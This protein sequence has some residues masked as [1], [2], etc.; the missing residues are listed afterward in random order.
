MH[1]RLLAEAIGIRLEPG[2]RE[3]GQDRD[4]WNRD[5]HP[6][7]VATAPAGQSAGHRLAGETERSGIRHGL[8]VDRQLGRRVVS[9]GRVGGQATSQDGLEG[10]GNRSAP[11]AGFGRTGSP[12]LQVSERGFGPG[13]RNDRPAADRLQEDQTQRVQ[14]RSVVDPAGLVLDQGL[15]VL[16]SHVSERAPDSIGSRG[17]VRGGVGQVEVQEHGQ[18]VLGDE[19]V[20][21]LD[22]AVQHAALVRVLQGLGQPRPPPGDR[23][24][25]GPPGQGVPTGRSWPV[26][27]GLEPVERVDERGPG[28]RGRRGRLGQDPSQGQPAEVRHAEEMEPSRRVGT[29]GV[30]G[31]NVGM[32]QPCQGLRLARAEPGD[33]EHD[34]P[35]GQPEL[36]GAEHPAKD[37]RPSSSTNRKPAIVCPDSGKLEP[38]SGSGG[39][40]AV[41][42]HSATKP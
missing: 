34:R 27:P 18:A 10:R 31:D 8:K 24:R 17:Q 25:V 2:G 9:V 6:H 30:D 1:F 4:D 22:V 36:L 14:I 12:G 26:A 23:P 3:P 7:P 11:V 5:R 15:D 41:L 29:V 19:D 16:R 35:I 21:R 38:A 13:R 42:G 20:G 32:L 37:P 40:G 28:T 33:L 39:W